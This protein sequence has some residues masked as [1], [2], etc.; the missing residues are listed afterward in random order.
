M[1]WN[2]LQPISHVLSQHVE[3]SA[4]LHTS[5]VAHLTSSNATLFS[6]GRLDERLSAHLDGVAVAGGAAWAYCEAAID[7][8]WPGAVFATSVRAVEARD[9]ERLENLFSLVQDQP[10]MISEL[11]SAFGWLPPDR[12]KGMVTALLK[13]GDPLR[14]MVGVAACARHRV[15]PGI[16]AGAYI[17]DVDPVVRSRSLRAAGELGIRGFA[18]PL[19]SLANDEPEC[20]TWGCWSAVLLGD[21]M[22]ALSMLAEDAMES[23]PLQSSA[24]QLV[25]LASEVQEGHA[26][27]QAC[28]S[29]PNKARLLIKGAGY[30]GDVRYVQWLI[31]QMVDKGLA[32]LAGESFSMITG[33]DLTQPPFF[34]EPTTDHEI[35]S[36]D[37]PMDDDVRVN[38]DDDLPWPNQDKVQAW[39]SQNGARFMPGVRHFSGAPI[40]RSHCAGVL[41]NGYQ[42]QRIAAA[43]HLSLLSPGTPLFE[44][45]APAWRQERELLGM[46]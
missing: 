41:K 9:Y 14:R 46:P 36:T 10:V 11:I 43:Y 23:S 25:L 2:S 17:G 26:L 24:F 22:R 18:L 21:R 4:A 40:S 37:D 8:A 6:L 28:A 1:R 3:E 19:A 27:L 31:A 33:L 7:E 44:W 32:R 30:V 35:V 34:I 42:R 39:W 12:L 5:R 16:T 20:R 15:D 29:D 45:R 13:S 38:E